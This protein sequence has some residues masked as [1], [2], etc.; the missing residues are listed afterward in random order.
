VHLVTDFALV[1]I[2]KYVF[3]LLIAHESTIFKSPR[4]C[5]PYM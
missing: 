3:L 1:I 5:L 2:K 4:A